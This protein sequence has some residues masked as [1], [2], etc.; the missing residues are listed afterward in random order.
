MIIHPIQPENVNKARIA[1]PSEEVLTVITELFKALG[2]STRA[3][4][5][6]VLRKKTL[7][8]RDISILVG[9][10][11]SAMSHQLRYL[12]KKHLVTHRRKGTIMY[13]SISYKH[14]SAL[15]KEAAHYADHVKNNHPDHPYTLA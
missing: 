4:V 12:K 15:L 14:I 11:E 8:V 10:S 9:I 7:C 5:L 2:D 1:L 6:Y 3:K 13:Y